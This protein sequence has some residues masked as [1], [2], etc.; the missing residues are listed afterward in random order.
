MGR[1]QGRRVE[2]GG[3]A[4]RLLQSGDS[5]GSACARGSF[6]QAPGFD[7]AQAVVGHEF[8]HGQCG[9]R[10]LLRTRPETNSIA[11]ADPR[12]AGEVASSAVVGGVSAGHSRAIV[13]SCFAWA[14]SLLR[15]SGGAR[16]GRRW[17]TGGT[18]RETVA[19]ANSVYSLAD[20]LD[21]I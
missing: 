12:L 15:T 13:L 1:A 9:F 3:E 18:D 6:E 19:C 10:S 11:A 8:H 14:D 5:R 7:W 2:S 21:R 20:A 4:I 17:R 16:I